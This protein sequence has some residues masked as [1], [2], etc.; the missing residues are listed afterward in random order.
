MVKVNEAVKIAEEW[1][2]IPE[3]EKWLWENPEAMKRLRD[4]IESVA[5]GNVVTVVMDF[6]DCMDIDFDAPDEDDE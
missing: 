2:E 4:S 5:Q 6:S 1:G 3:R